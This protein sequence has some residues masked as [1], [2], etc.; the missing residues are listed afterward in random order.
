[1]IIKR[2]FNYEATASKLLMPAAPRPHSSG[3]RLMTGQL[4]I[5]KFENLLQNKFA[6]KMWVTIAT[7][8][9]S[10]VCLIV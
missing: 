3:D 2:K 6:L 1:M 10:Q 9:L 4:S 5:G 7:V 8:R